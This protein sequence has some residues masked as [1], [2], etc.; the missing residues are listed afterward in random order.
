MK[1]VLAFLFLFS[2]VF[3]SSQNMDIVKGDFSFL[4]GQKEINTEF[5]YSK[6]TLM[7]D[8]ISEEQYI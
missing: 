7:K 1:K 2:S 5:D 6:L 3:V 8:K 4:N